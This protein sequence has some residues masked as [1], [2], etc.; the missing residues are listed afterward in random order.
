MVLTE[1]MTAV[2]GPAKAA[3]AHFD[4]IGVGFGP[5]NLALAIALDDVERHTGSG[6]THH[7][8]EKQDRFTWH[9]GMLLPDS[10]MQISFMKDL[11]SL[12]NPTSPFTFINYLHVK[13]RLEAFINQKTFFPSRIEFNDYLSW[14]A[15]HFDAQC[16]YGEEVLSI[17]P[18]PLR[19]G[20]DSLRVISRNLSGYEVVRRTDNLAIAVGGAPQIPETF[21]PL[22]GDA[23][24]FHSAHYLARIAGLNLTSAAGTRIAVIGG[25]QS[26]AE[27]VLDLLVRFPKLAVDMIF[28]GYALK[29]SD[30]TPFVNEIFDPEFISFIF[31]QPESRRRDFLKEF[32]NTNY[33]VV[34]GDLIQKLYGILYQQRVGGPKRLRLQ[35]SSEILAVA[36][37]PGGIALSIK[38]GIGGTAAV[39]HY[40]AVVLATGYERDSCRALLAQVEPYIEDFS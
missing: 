30:D 22:A 40:D 33:A 29:P 9:G 17:A 3:P 19:N 28:R 11:V 4:L 2:P 13:G 16:S 36:A 38:D 7:F 10:D 25:G 8:V 6:A 37:E 24:V 31:S 26:A 27:I 12:R 23:R 34:D 14:V 1:R 5:S 21:R 18:E 15:G 32:R 20:V 35:S 39:R